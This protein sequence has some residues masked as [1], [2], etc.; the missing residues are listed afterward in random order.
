VHYSNK[1][2]HEHIYLIALQCTVNSLESLQNK[3]GKYSEQILI[4]VQTVYKPGI[5]NWLKKL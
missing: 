2:Q 3:L 4:D 5:E 1:I